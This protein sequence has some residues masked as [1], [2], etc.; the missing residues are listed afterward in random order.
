[1][2][3]KVYTF[4][5]V[6]FDYEYLNEDTLPQKADVIIGLG[7]HDIHVAEHVSELYT[8][9]VASLVIFTGGWGRITKELWDEPESVRF[10][11]IAIQNG[12]PKDKIVLDM[13]AT[14]TGMNISNAKTIISE[15]GINDPLIIV[16]DRPYRQRRTK[17]AFEAQWPEADIILSS[18]K[19]SFDDYIDFYN[20][21]GPIDTETFINILVGDVQR[22]VIYAEKGLQTFQPL[23]EEV[24]NA[25]KYLIEAG[26]TSQIIK[27]GPMSL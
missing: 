11:K 10:S 4:A 14:N 18:P 1:M 16:V 9:G 23:T 15:R 7:S 27:E 2:D 22:N 5:K 20:Q 24:K 21:Q 26:Y 8:K 19:L 13:F 6:L 25:Y 12:V 3:K 17:A